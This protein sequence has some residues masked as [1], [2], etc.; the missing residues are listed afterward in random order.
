MDDW[1]HNAAA[2]ADIL[3]RAAAALAS[4]P[5]RVAS[6]VRLPAHGRL[7]VTGDVHDNRVHFEAAVRA[8]RLEASADHHLVVQ[9]II[10]GEGAVDGVDMSHRLLV[11]VAEL[12]LAH[13]GQV[14]PILANH[15][16]AQFRGH[17]ITKGGV[18]CTQA[19]DLG[20]AEAYG[21][22]AIQVAE[23]VGRF[24][25]AMPLAVV[26][27]NG[28]MVSHS[29]PGAAVMRFFDTRVIE[30]ALYDEDFDPPYGAAHLLTWGRMHSADQLE[31]LA[32]EW[33]VRVFIAGHEPAPDGVLV[34]PPNMVILNTGHA[35]GRLIDLDL[36]KAA[37]TA[38]D[39]AAAAMP[40]SLL[41]PDQVTPDTAAER[42]A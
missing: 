30:R 34:R 26:C 19:F 21:D 35:S 9:E 23:A 8:A 5:V 16:I 20:L 11:R 1:R 25:A 38:A 10:H 3:T 6:V 32:R 13:P 14:H 39:L 42:L 31:E 17:G 37:P 24:I 22:D 33:G 40:V 41:L 7:L 36:A 12:V 27:A 18:H 28:A 4:S 29:L 15:E 2:C